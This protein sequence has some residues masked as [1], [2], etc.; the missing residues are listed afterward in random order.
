VKKVR[1]ILFGFTL[2]LL[3]FSLAGQQ[4]TP[5]MLAAARKTADAGETYFHTQGY[6]GEEHLD[7]AAAL[8]YSEFESFL[9]IP[10][11]PFLS[12]VD[13]LHLPY[14]RSPDNRFFI[15]SWDER[16]GGTFKSHEN[17]SVEVDSAGLYWSGFPDGEGSGEYGIVTID[18][19]Q[20]NGGVFYFYEY[21]AYV[22]SSM[23]ETDIT[24]SDGSGEWHD[25]FSWY[26]PAWHEPKGEYDNVHKIYMHFHSEPAAYNMAGDRDFTRMGKDGTFGD[27]SCI[28][29]DTEGRPRIAV[30]DVVNLRKV[31][32]EKW[33]QPAED[34]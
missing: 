24:L 32:E 5:E 23:A 28:I 6:A 9:S 11:L 14:Q 1:F 8:L 20:Y 31:L 2:S 10:D 17:I 19:I 33:E 29:W 4:I 25:S 16:T 22:S 3:S 18:T 7:S 26:Y 12:L 21:M 34:E 30:H 15:F 27:S 13:S